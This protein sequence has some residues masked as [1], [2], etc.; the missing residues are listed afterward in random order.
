MEEIRVGVFICNCG[1]NI[2][3]FLDAA[4][5]A[6]YA[7]SL[8]DVVF[9]RENLFSCSE[10][11]ITDIK[12]AIRDNGLTR[13]VVAAC[14]PIT[15]EPTFRAACED[16]GLNPYLFE[17]ANIRE[18]CSW[19]HKEER[20]AATKKAK[21]LVRMAVA[22]ARLLE[23]QTRIT[24]GVLGR[25]VVIGGGV[26]GLTAALA[27]ARKG[28]DVTLVER[29]RKLGGLVSQL[30]TLHP[31]GRDAKEY[32]DSL[33]AAVKKSRRIK[34]LVGAAPKRVSGYIGNYLVAVESKGRMQEIECGAIVLATGARPLSAEG[35]YGYDGRRVITL[36][37]L[38]QRLRKG[39]LGG[40]KFV[41]I[42]CAGARTSERPYCSKVC[43]AAATKDALLIKEAEPESTVHVLYR[44]LMCCG[45]AN[46]DLLRRA[47]EAG[48]RFVS[49]SKD[50]P[51]V[52]EDGLV[53]VMANVI[54][55]E[56]ALECDVVVLA[57]PLV[58][59]EDAGDIS[60][61]LKV[62]L[63]EDRF[64]LEAH[65]KLRPVDF[66]TDGIYVCGTARWPAFTH[67]S[68]EQALAAAGRA[69]IPV[70]SG[71][72][73]VE[74]TVSVLADEESCRGCGMC[75]S[76]CPY[77]AIEIV[78]T[79]RGKKARMIEVACKGCGTCAATC[80]RRAITMV[81]YT[82]DQVAAQV[83]AAFSE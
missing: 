71:E 38:E 67:E 5:V 54:G 50:S 13:V 3:G 18:H 15:H 66:A 83:R 12:S 49:Y 29:A 9:T 52:V 69:S 61:M 32:V 34:V 80:Y 22:R 44:D 40:R 76:L 60:K 81:H 23:P 48:I 19:V 46:E 39:R 4:D 77:S 28:V 65:V 20:E 62:P 37:E 53:R 63:D 59:R 27:L 57:V 41:M 68:I 24:A 25:V 14:T 78:E 31:G 70:L 17:F 79:E 75:A 21:D 72:V 64:F 7:A 26:S 73:E 51:P 82:D 10:G 33:I 43:C 16:A 74:P 47:K 56:L 42:K 30:Y 36:L 11:G 58:A 2:A 6:H 55:T 1:T 35:L 45:V 8:P